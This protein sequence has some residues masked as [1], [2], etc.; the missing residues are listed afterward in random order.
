MMHRYFVHPFLKSMKRWP[1]FIL[2]VGIIATLV[3]AGLRNELG[4]TGVR[5]IPS[6]PAPFGSEVKMLVAI[7]NSNGNELYEPTEL[8]KNGTNF[9]IFIYPES[10][11]PAVIV[12]ITEVVSLGELPIGEY[13]YN[14]QLRLKPVAAQSYRGVSNYFGTF[15]VAPRLTATATQTEAVLRWPASASNFVLQIATRV[16]PDADWANVSNA[17]LK[18]ADEFVLTNR[19][20][21]FHE[22]YRL[23]KE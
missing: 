11:G 7:M 2:G 5:I 8:V 9:S 16:S 14:V 13:N 17:P 4:I 19:L 6:N 22:F 1:F 12:G 20:E 21:R 3:N 10:D 18:S 15:F 23:R